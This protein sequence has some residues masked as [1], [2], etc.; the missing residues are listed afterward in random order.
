MARVQSMVREVVEAAGDE[1]PMEIVP[2]KEQVDSSSV[3]CG[4]DAECESD[5]GSRGD[6]AHANEASCSYF[7]VHHLLRL[8]AFRK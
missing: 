4:S 1:I 7:L 3:N 6:D 8:A 2:R 5:V